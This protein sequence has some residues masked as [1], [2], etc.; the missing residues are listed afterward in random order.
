[1]YFVSPLLPAAS[2]YAMPLV[3]TKTS[4]APPTSSRYSHTHSKLKTLNTPCLSA[5]RQ[6][7]KASSFM[8]ATHFPG[9]RNSLENFPH[10]VNTVTVIHARPPRAAIYTGNARPHSPVGNN[11]DHLQVENKNQTSTILHTIPC[12][13]N[14]STAPIQNVARFS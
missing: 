11:S 6:K 3:K 13:P 8:P 12:T 1:M 9:T 14:P 4:T 5:T 10:A 2:Q 7:N